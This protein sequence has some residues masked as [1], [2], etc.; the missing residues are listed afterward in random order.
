M[1]NL[2]SPFKKNDTQPVSVSLDVELYSSLDLELE[3]SLSLS[4]GVSRL[5]VEL[6]TGVK[7]FH[8]VSM[9]M[10]FIVTNKSTS[11]PPL[12]LSFSRTRSITHSESRASFF[13]FFQTSAHRA[14]VQCKPRGA[15]QRWRAAAMQLAPEN[16][17][18]LS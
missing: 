16:L 1:R 14:E 18:R 17:Y 6:T 7:R 4:W 8:K 3:L 5:D 2:V 15:V 11:R 12:E 13:S 9:M 10:F